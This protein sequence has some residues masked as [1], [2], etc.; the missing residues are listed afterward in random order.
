MKVMEL[1]FSSM[2]MEI[3]PNNT[4]IL[5]SEYAI[6]IHNI[7]LKIVFGKITV[8]DGPEKGCRFCYQKFSG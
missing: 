8:R 5:N 2:E 1:L 7:L 4:S 6:T 3:L